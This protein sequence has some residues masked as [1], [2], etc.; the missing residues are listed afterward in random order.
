[1]ARLP[2][3]FIFS[4]L[5]LCRCCVV[6]AGAR[7]RHLHFLRLLSSFLLPVRH[8]IINLVRCT[9]QV[10]SSW[11][12]IGSDMSDASN[13]FGHVAGVMMSLMM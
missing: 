12:L 11:F 2:V 5:V 3:I 10:D 9:A 8:R 4:S 7:A 6:F 13:F 1:M